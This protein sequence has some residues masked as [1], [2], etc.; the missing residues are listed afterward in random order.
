MTI[1]ILRE[2]TKRFDIIENIE[3]TMALIVNQFD[4]IDNSNN[5]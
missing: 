3:L 1:N 2:H 5:Q 4:S